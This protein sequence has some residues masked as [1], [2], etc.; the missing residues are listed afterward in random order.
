MSLL[1]VDRNFIQIHDGVNPMLAAKKHDYGH[2]FMATGSTPL[3]SMP[4]DA[5]DAAVLSCG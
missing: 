1:K 4:H 5:F 2:V 3:K